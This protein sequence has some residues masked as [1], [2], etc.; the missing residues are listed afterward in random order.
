MFD[1]FSPL[2][3]IL[4]RL[5][6]QA[7]R[8]NINKLT[9]EFGLSGLTPVGE[10][11]AKFAA[12]TLSVLLAYA[13]F[14]A[15]TYDG[16]ERDISSNATV[17]IEFVG[18][19][20]ITL[21]IVGIVGIFRR[22]RSAINW[23]V[24]GLLT[25][26]LLG[27]T[28]ALINALMADKSAVSSPSEAFMHIPVDTIAPLLLISYGLAGSLIF[29][30]SR[31]PNRQE[32]RAQAGL[33]WVIVALIASAFVAVLF[34]R[35]WINDLNYMG[36]WDLLLAISLI[37]FCLGFA[38]PLRQLDFT[39]SE[40]RNITFTAC[41]FLVILV[42]DS[43]LPLG[44]AAGVAYV[45]LLYF[46][47]DFLDRKSPLVLATIATAF[48]LGGYLESSNIGVDN[49]HVVM[50]RVLS[51]IA[52]WV[53]AW[54]MYRQQGYQ[55]QLK[56][57]EDALK[58]GWR[59]A[60][61]GM[62]DWNV[63]T[64]TVIFSDR[65]IELIGYRPGEIDFHYDEWAS[66]LHPEDVKKTMANLEAHLTDKTPY[67][68]EYRLKNK[69]GSWRWYLAR[70]QALWNEKNIPTRMAGS[71]TD[72]TESKEVNIQLRLFQTAVDLSKDVVFITDANPEDPRIIHVNKACADLTGYTP[73]E[74]M[75]KNPNILQGEETNR[76]E[77]RRIKQALLLN[78]PVSVELI[79]YAK[80]GRKY[81]IEINIVP[82]V[83]EQ[84]IT[85]N[86][87]SLQRDITF[88]KI[89]EFYREHLIEALEKSNQ[90][91]DD[92]AYIASHDL[93][94][95]LRVIDN[96]S[97]W[98]EEDLA[99]KLD[100][101]SKENLK[102]LRSR[103]VRMEKLLDDLLEYSRIGR[104]SSAEYDMELSGEDLFGCILDLVNVPE[105]FAVTCDKSFKSLTLKKMPLLVIF[106]NLI[107][108]A[109]KHHD[110]N[111]GK[112]EVKGQ[113]D[114]NTLI[115]RV[116]D[117][118]PGI[119]KQFHQKVFKMFQ[120]LRPRDQVEG[121]GMGLAVVKKHLDSVGGKI[122]IISEEG[123][124]TE[125]KIIWPLESQKSELEMNLL[126]MEKDTWRI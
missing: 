103:V 58:L 25:V 111:S 106:I 75:G 100:D 36:C 29:F 86:F 4:T 1:D 124:G 42:F 55:R 87:A 66:R 16:L 9:K 8:N 79:N 39:S 3:N 64:N 51:V 50:N 95:P 34:Y 108:N 117:D 24:A 57:S 110:K 7:I 77:T 123:V 85:T 48:T 98:L 53:V 52:I 72:I 119:P 109:L 37:V 19:L 94:A 41:G 82:I 11:L 6:I 33:L 99:D 46:S 35:F 83:N 125:F 73:E 32:M 15:T 62:W 80:D 104:K 107:N 43:L 113:S 65:F 78:Q 68:V 93:K 40:V 88:N 63:A 60:G 84:G 20:F 21:L 26:S 114:G 67:H 38:S 10:K 97:C 27:F 17:L 31:S 23:A 91:L 112:V 54:I 105:G 56:E 122:E 30:Y 120:T 92:F 101:E 96:A 14:I 49:S 115:F 22:W 59:G 74:L 89:T 81:W 118:G 126:N 121:S 12:I 102:L 76:D 47:N 70:G 45:P 18:V 28:I 44:I 61:D 90:E 2:V 13:A 69:D 71:L 116:I 5:Y